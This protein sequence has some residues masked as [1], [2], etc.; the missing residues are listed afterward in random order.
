MLNTHITLLLL[1]SSLSYSDESP[2]D[3]TF[4]S[5]DSA[6]SSSAPAEAATETSEEDEQGLHESYDN[7]M[8][9]FY[10]KQT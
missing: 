10:N 7:V 4:S 5:T 9:L 8:S 2:L 3:H 1:F 6:P